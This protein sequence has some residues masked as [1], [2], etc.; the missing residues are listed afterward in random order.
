MSFLIILIEFINLKHYCSYITILLQRKFN[1]IKLF[2]L[3]FFLF[4]Q[5]D[6]ITSTVAQKGGKRIDDDIERA[7]EVK[8][9]ELI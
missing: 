6:R 5:V 7:F 3:N 2:S 9:I 4:F 1:T 8:L